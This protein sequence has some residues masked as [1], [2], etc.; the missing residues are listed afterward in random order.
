MKIIGK[1]IVTTVCAISILLY[2]WAF[3][4][5]CDVVADNRNPNPVHSEYNLFVMMTEN[6]G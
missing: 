6:R 1:A 5:W 4:S 2:A 3:A